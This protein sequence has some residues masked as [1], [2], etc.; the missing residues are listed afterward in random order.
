MTASGTFASGREFARLRRPV[1]SRRDRDQG[2]LARAVAGQRQPAHR[3]D[4][5]RHA[6]LHRPAEPRCRGVRRA[7]PRLAGEHSRR[8]PVIVNVSGHSVDEYVRVIERLEDRA[9]R[10][11]RTRSTSPAPT[12]TR[13]AWRSAPTARPRRAVTAACRAATGRTA[14]RQALPQRDRHRLR[15]PRSVEA[16]GADARVAHQ[17]AA[18]HGDRRRDAPA[19][20]GARRRRAVRPGDQAGR[21]ADGVAGRQPPSASRSSAWA[22]SWTARTPSSSCS[23]GRP[24]WPWVPPTSST[25]PRRCAWST[26][27]AEYCREHGV[28]RVRRTWSE[29][30]RVRAFVERFMVTTSARPPE[31][32][33]RTHPRRDGESRSSSALVVV[34]LDLA[35]AAACGSS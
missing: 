20:A 21:A 29:R 16:E 19:E 7:R 28:G 32:R 4:G 30:W 35:R 10:R 23:P 18:R 34:S 33:P 22:A 27:S 31:P 2:R 6:Q 17:H 5:Q 13:A 8:P 1:A 24:P 3:R 14:H 11:R 15:S 26:G 12:S 9:G 25:R